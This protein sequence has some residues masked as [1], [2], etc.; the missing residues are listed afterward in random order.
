MSA[1]PHR[2]GTTLLTREDRLIFAALWVA[3][4]SLYLLSSKGVVCSNDGSHFALIRAMARGT[5]RIDPD[6]EL[7]EY[8][9]LAQYK[10]HYYSD[11]PP[12]AAA[13]ALPLHLL[14]KA[15][16]PPAL[17]EQATR[18]A[19]PLLPALAGSLSVALLFVLAR[20][21]GGGR[22]AAL[23]PAVGLGTGTFQWM[24][25]T[26]LFSHVVAGAAV[27]SAVTLM[28]SRAR[29]HRLP[30]GSAVAIGG[31]LAS[32]PVFDYPTLGLSLVSA[33][34][35]LLLRLEPPFP[36]RKRV[37]AMALGAA[38]PLG[39]FAVYNTICFGA[40]WSYS[41]AHHY[42]PWSR[43]LGETFFSPLRGMTN[44]LLTGPGNVNLFRAAPL[45]LLAVAGFV[46]LWRRDRGV[47]L[48]TL[49]L[50]SAQL[51]LVSGHRYFFGHGRADTRYLVAAKP[52]LM[53]P[54]FALIEAV[55][56]RESLKPL[57]PLLWAALLGLWLRSLLNQ[58]EEVAGFYHHGLEESHLKFFAPQAIPLWPR[59]ILPALYDSVALIVVVAAIAALSAALAMWLAI[60]AR[61][62][63]QSVI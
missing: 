34:Y 59:W 15:L 48:L 45:F 36:G 1:S 57:R 22:A 28:L 23:M 47:A 46:P 62:A 12:G 41:L 50:F 58:M 61:R 4:F 52:F 43:H 27:L 63:P 10:G 19:V 18:A 6:V 38:L 51:L 31:L 16:A 9:D 30:F 2:E 56:R 17:E 26:T 11:R 60:S 44:F 49:G 14:V 39:Y 40:P 29:S 35:F 54:L 42:V 21:L 32:A 37:A 5:F 7:T 24:Y 25:S 3:A 53:L 55:Y 20:V 33:T 13:L 8:R